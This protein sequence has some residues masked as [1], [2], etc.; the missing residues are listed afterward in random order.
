MRETELRIHRAN[1]TAFISENPTQISL[2]PNLRGRTAGGGFNEQ[3]G[4]PRPEQTFRVIELGMRTA[5]PLLRG[6]NGTQREA[7]Y[8]LLGEHDAVVALHDSWTTEDG[9]EWEVV[10][11]LP[12][13]GYETRAVVSERG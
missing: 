9:R 13:N 1:T 2:R 12:A 6:Q 5:P 7:R 3:P 10:E 4:T 8:W 11:I